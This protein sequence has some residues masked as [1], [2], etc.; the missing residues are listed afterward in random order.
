MV[1]GVIGF[2]FYMD[3]ATGQ[4]EYMAAV[5]V[6]GTDAIPAGMTS[7]VVPTNTYAV[8]E[9]SLAGIGNAFSYVYNT[10]MPSSGYQHALGPYFERYGETFEP[11][12]PSSTLSIYIPVQKS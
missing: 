1:G 6:T 11:A 4:L 2:V 8:F 10:W 5:S 9:T 12:D 3:M 7:L